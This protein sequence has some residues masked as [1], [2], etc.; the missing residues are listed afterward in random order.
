MTA[1]LTLLALLAPRGAPPPA[2]EQ[3]V[4]VVD[5]DVPEPAIEAAPEPP[6]VDAEGRPVPRVELVFIDVGD[7]AYSLYGHA[8]FLAVT[9]PAAPIGDAELFNFGVTAFGDTD[10]VRDFLGGRVEFWGDSRPYGRQLARWK[11][12]DRTVVR[13]VIDLD[14][15]VAARL[16]DQLRHD[17]APE[18]RNYVYD[19]F[20]DNCSTRLRDYLDRYTGGAVYAALGAVETERTYRDDVRVAYAGLAPLLALTEIVPGPELDRVRTPWELAYLPAA[21]MSG[22]RMV[23]TDRGPLLGEA[24]VEYTR[25]GGDPREGWPHIGQAIVAAFAL[26][27]LLLAL[28][29]PRFGPRL[30][31]ALLAAWALGSAGLGLV[32]VA[33]GLGSAWPDMQRNALLVACP[34]TDL[35]LLV[36][37]VALWR[38]RPAGGPVARAYLAARAATTLLLLALTP[39]GGAFAGPYPARLLALVGVA[40]A[41]RALGRAPVEVEARPRRLLGN[42]TGPFPAASAQRTSRTNSHLYSRVGAGSLGDLATEGRK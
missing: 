13:A 8:G 25:Q 16:I 5:E 30:R 27:T 3:P 19:T 36:P 7:D 35:L 39:L 2:V 1:L 41:W 14:R 21:L 12:E 31:G 40:L 24:T 33:I 42:Q 4:E 10:Y 9:D 38:R 6:A 32:L 29:A 26:V 15:D 17:I 34:P 37:A 11:R 18:R 22:L 20:R 28:L 23:T